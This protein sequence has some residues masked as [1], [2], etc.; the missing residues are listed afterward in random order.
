MSRNYYKVLI[1]LISLILINGFYFGIRYFELGPAIENE[2]F[3]PTWFKIQMSMNLV[4]TILMAPYYFF[5][6]FMA[7]FYLS[8][9][10]IALFILEFI[11]GISR[12]NGR[13]FNILDISL[14]ISLFLVSLFYGIA[15]FRTNARTRPYLKIFGYVLTVLTPIYMI[16]YILVVSNPSAGLEAALLS[17]FKVFEPIVQL[18]P[19][20]YILNFYSELKETPETRLATDQ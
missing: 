9:V 5:K 15:F 3:L 2:A 18:L 13:G 11:A 6:K 7:N 10:F 12:F 14:A 17:F 1:L 16:A 19:I 20:F 8:F 4:A